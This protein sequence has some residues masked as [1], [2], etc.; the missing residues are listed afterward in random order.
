M[1]MIVTPNID[2]VKRGTLIGFATKFGSKLGG[3]LA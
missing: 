3:I 1:E 2:V